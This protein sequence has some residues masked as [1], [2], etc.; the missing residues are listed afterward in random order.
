MQFYALT[1][2]E[3]DEIIN[4]TIHNKKYRK[5]MHLRYV[6]GM[7]YESIA[8]EMEMSPRYIRSI[9]K[10]LSNNALKKS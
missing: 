2:S 8:D 5:I 1:N 9:V 10:K 6:D 4:E 3:I 7:T